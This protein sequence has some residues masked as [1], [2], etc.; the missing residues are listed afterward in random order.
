MSGTVSSALDLYRAVWVDLSPSDSDGARASR[1]YLIGQVESI[2]E[3]VDDFPSLYNGGHHIPFGSFARKTKTQDLD[4]IDV[5]SVLHGCGG[6]AISTGNYTYQVQIPN[7]TRPLWQYTENGYVNSTKILNKYKSELAGVPNYSSAAINKHGEAVVVK[8][9]S[10]DWSFDL[11]PA[12]AVSDIEDA[13]EHFLIP[14]GKGTWKRTDPR[15][16]QKRITQENQRH[17]GHLLGLIRL[18]KYWNENSGHAR[19]IGSYHLE[20]MLINGLSTHEPLESVKAGVI[21]AFSILQSGILNICA[22]PK[23]LELP[24]DYNM[25]ITEKINFSNATAKMATQLRDA[26]LKEIMGEEKEAIKIWEEVFP[27]FPNFT[28]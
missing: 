3:R 19:T 18:I 15:R 20:T 25:D 14:D 11:V 12:F 27:D 7:T 17:N 5:M 28:H 23:N 24:L 21:P 10:Y 16:D 4:D 1:D 13:I 6:T 9:S 26:F 22:D 8:L 2:A